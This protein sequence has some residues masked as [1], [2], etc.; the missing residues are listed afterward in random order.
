MILCDLFY[1][2][3]AILIKMMNFPQFEPI[4]DLQYALQRRSA[5]TKHDE[6]HH[7]RYLI[8]HNS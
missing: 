3:F 5:D 2:T 1:G 6:L 8:S 4:K 7:F